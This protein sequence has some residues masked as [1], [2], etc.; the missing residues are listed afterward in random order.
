MATYVMTGGASGIG[1]ATRTLLTDQGDTVITLDLQNADFNA[2]LGDVAA[3]ST[4]IDT[5][6]RAH[7]SIDGLITCA[8][9]AS[10]FPDPAKILAINYFGTR[11]IIEGLADCLLPG[12]RIVAISS[13]SAPMCH[14]EALIQAMLDNNPDQAFEMATASNGHECYA[15]SKQAVARWMRRVAPEYARR[16]IAFNAVAPG[17][18]ETPMTAAVAESPEY[19][20]AIQEFVQS[21]P[22]GRAGQPG[23]VADLIGF[24]LSP[25]ASF[26]SGSLIYCDGAHDALMRAEGLF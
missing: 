10:H 7:P 15:G 13:N 20:A 17:Y 2:D 8:G 22:I 18:I 3:R 1:A 23:D 6:R 25:H 16:G 5:V 21:I 14:N 9:V 11:G 4:V 26:I 19:G 12:G 24:L